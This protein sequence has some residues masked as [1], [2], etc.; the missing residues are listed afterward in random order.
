MRQPVANLIQSNPLRIREHANA[1]TVLLVL[2]FFLVGLGG[3]AY[4]HHR[5]TK[6]APLKESDDKKIIALSDSTKAVLKR[7]ES[8]VEIRFYSL[9]DPATVSDSMQAFAGRVDQLLIA[10]QQEANGQINVT[11]F[12]SQPDANAQAAAA[13]GIKPFNRD[14]GEACY[15][16]IAVAQKEQ[17]E[18]LPQLSPEWEPAVEFDLTRAIVRLMDAKSSATNPVATSEPNKATIEEVKRA[19]PNL[20]AVSMEEGT[21]ILRETTLKEFAAAADEMEIR[22]K[23]AQQRATQAQS[24]GSAADQQAAV[25][26]LQQVQL[27]Q[28][29]KLK[30]ITARLSVRI[31]ALQQLKKE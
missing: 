19:L 9:L 8:P 15:L 25:K 30:E 26:Q 24:S 23:E 29:E 2:V 20:A 13:D 7:L 6:S 17:K 4:W 11:R 31:A 5:S 12:N 18:S 3:G 14:K 10:Y 22:L 27:E 1:R 28:A 16:G 21:R